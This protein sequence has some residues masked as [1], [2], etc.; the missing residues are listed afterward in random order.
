[1]AAH[2]ETLGLDEGYANFVERFG[3][4]DAAFCG[5]TVLRTRRLRLEELTE[6]HAAGMYDG[7]RDVALYRYTDDAPPADLE[8][9]RARYARLQQR[10]SP[11]GRAHW[12]NWIVRTNDD[13]RYLG[14]V[15][16]TVAT[17]GAEALI[18]YVIFTAA[19]RRGYGAEAVAA[20]LA[21]VS[22]TYSPG[23]FRATVDRR[24]DASIRLLQRLGFV[25][26]DGP[27]ASGDDDFVLRLAADR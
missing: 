8:A 14:Y 13:G 2:R 22:A 27:R 6:A 9:L 26:T 18:G 3:H 19:Q 5:A 1:M 17:D 4:D 7:L 12:L 16:A 15:Q 24:N 10:C 23:V 21:E 20:M 25:V 11:D